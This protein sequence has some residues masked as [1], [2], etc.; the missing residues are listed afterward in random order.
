MR[1]YAKIKHK[2]V[3]EIIILMFL[4]TLFVSG[5]SQTKPTA[6]IRENTPKVHALINARIV[7]A[8]GRV[9]EKGT[10]VIRNGIITSVG[11]QISLPADARIWNYE[12]LTI[13][14]GFIETYSHI[15]LP[16]EKK[17]PRQ[18][19]AAAQQSAPQRKG[20]EHWNPHVLAEVNA[21]DNFQPK[22]EDL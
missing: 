2:V 11:A 9:I 3:P 16:K 10:I 13:Y 4:L 22:K 21:M 20:P 5:W 15:G 17:T 18:P 1:Y 7:Q 12:G 8:P 14:P 6:G 19:G